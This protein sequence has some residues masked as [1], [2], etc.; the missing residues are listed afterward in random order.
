[1]T[2]L[3]D[4]I[5]IF[6]FDDTLFETVRFKREIENIFLR[7]KVPKSLFLKTYDLSRKEKEAWQPERQI[8]IL[9]QKLPWLK[10]KV[11]LSQ[12]NSLFKKAKK[13]IFPDVVPFL[14]KLRAQARKQN[15]K[16]ILITFGQIEV[17]E[18]KI[19][20]SKIRR[21]FDR[22]IMATSPTKEREIAKL[23]RQEK[24][25]TVIFIE[26]RGQVIDAVKK[27]SPQ[28]VSILMARPTG[29]FRHDKCL[30][31]NFKVANLKQV[32]KI[33]DI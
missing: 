23:L 32:E 9:R 31:A 13:F 20:N 22:I 11:I 7:Y 12:I 18:S 29:R 10:R 5:I 33:L 27:T 17:Q 26:D 16:I 21:F 24:N 15:L 6:D 25:K 8:S 30:L 14:R 4:K 1:M 28:V 2:K 19:K 3:P